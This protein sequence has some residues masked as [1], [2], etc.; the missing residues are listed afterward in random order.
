MT[1]SS[2]MHAANGVLVL[3]GVLD[4][5]IGQALRALLA[6]SEP[7]DLRRA[8]DE[9]WLLLADEAEMLRHEL[10]GNAWQ[11]HLLD[12]LVSD[13]N[14]FSRKLQHASIDEIGPAVRQAV[15][16]DLER[17]Q[18]LYNLDIAHLAQLAG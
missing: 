10:A 13:E 1:T 4:D 5:A 17:L 12:R 9:F 7:E 11:N 16:E 8:Y 2:A 15:T 18:I 14:I 3:R 6:A